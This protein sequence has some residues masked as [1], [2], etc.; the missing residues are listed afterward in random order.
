MFERNSE[1]I[2]V[3]PT[4]QGNITGRSYTK[5]PRALPLEGT[6]HGQELHKSTTSITFGRETSRQELHKSTKSITFAR[7]ITRAGIT[8]RY[9][10]HYLRK[11][12]ITCRNYTKV[13]RALPLEGKHH[14]QD[15]HKGITSIIFAWETSRQELHKGITSITSVIDRS[16]RHM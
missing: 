4:R 6:H 12:N 14:G 5:V 10:E 8:Q 11:G 15:L 16:C 1:Q 13:P 7:E 2:A 9:H 3:V